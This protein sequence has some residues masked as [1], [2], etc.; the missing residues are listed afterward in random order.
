M[1]QIEILLVILFLSRK[2]FHSKQ[3]FVLSSS[4]KLG[5]DVLLT[6]CAKSQVS[7]TCLNTQY[8]G[9][10]CT[11]SKPT[12]E[13][14]TNSLFKTVCIYVRVP[15]LTLQSTGTQTDFPQ[16]FSVLSAPDRENSDDLPTNH[17]IAILS[18]NSHE[19]IHWRMTFCSMC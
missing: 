8:R 5:P 1:Q 12:L 10:E 3:M 4:M 18:T 13:A 7:N 19:N 11:F 16:M 6:A 9:Q 2:K 15:P 14:A 17:N